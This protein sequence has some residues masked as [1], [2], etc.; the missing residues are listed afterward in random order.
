MTQKLFVGLLHRTSMRRF[1]RV[2]ALLLVI[3]SLGMSREAEAA[4]CS[5]T[6]E[7]PV[8]PPGVSGCVM[9]T[10]GG[11]PGPSQIPSHL[12]TFDCATGL[13]KGVRSIGGGCI[14]APVDTCVGTCPYGPCT[15]GQN[16]RSCG[17]SVG[18]C[19]PGTQSCNIT[20]HPGFPAAQDRTQFGQWAACAGE[21]KPSA[22]K[23]D[24]KD[25]DCDGILNNVP[26][27]GTACTVGIGSCTRSGTHVCKG[28][29]GTECNAIAG[30]PSVEACDGLDNDCDGEADD[31]LECGPRGPPGP[32]MPGGVCQGR[33]LRQDRF[34]RTQRAPTFTAVPFRQLRVACSL[35]QFPLR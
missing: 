34:P 6:F 4:S 9:N 10:C 21:I 13:S 19:S 35:A 7:V 33:F 20:I 18:A 24:G 26:G 11:C 15:E 22:E 29:S 23:C 3:V 27:I 16:A 17:S 2:F 31:G 32:P 25:H 28:G 12:E 30:A 8:C 5:G 1:A 14:C